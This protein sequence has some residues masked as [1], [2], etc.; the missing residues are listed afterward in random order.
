MVVKSALKRR[1]L[2]KFSRLKLPLFCLGG[3]L[4]LLLGIYLVHCSLSPESLTDDQILVKENWTE[5]ELIQSATQRLQAKR[6]SEG[7]AEVFKRLQTQIRRLPAERQDSVREAIMR[8]AVASGLREYRLLAADK[9]VELVNR[10]CDQAERRRKEFSSGLAKPKN[11]AEE[12]AIKDGQVRKEQ[13]A[14]AMQQ[15]M[16]QLTPDERRDLKNLVQKWVQIAETL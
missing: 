5:E 6:R 8:E 11:P 3:T 10:M 16:D 15:I 12:A 9:K 14:R 13:A 7:N 2:G 1:P 4:L